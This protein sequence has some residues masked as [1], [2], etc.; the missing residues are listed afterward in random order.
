MFDAD[1]VDESSS[2]DGG[3]LAPRPLRYLFF[4]K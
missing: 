1:V 2:D 3:F 4:D